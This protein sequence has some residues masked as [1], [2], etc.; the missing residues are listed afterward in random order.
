MEKEV[1][2]GGSK[3]ASE[4]Q[5]TIRTS[6]VV[7]T[8]YCQEVLYRDKEI[9]VAFVENIFFLSYGSLHLAILSL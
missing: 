1:N 3:N 5:Q 6:T 4:V 9:T 7:V 2:I 8:L